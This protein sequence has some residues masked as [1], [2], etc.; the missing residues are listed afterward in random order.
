MPELWEDAIALNTHSDLEFELLPRA[1][2]LPER[3]VWTFDPAAMAL[4]A[5]LEHYL[6]ADVWPLPVPADRDNYY[7]PRHF[8]YWLSGLGVALETVAY[9]KTYGVRRGAYLELGSGSGRVMRHMAANA[10]FETCW[11]FDINYR[12]TVWINRNLSGHIR[13]VQN[14]AI[15]H[16]PIEDRSI[17]CVSAMSVFTHIDSFE[18]Q[19]LAELRRIMKPGAIALITIVTDHQLRIM[20]PEWP[21]YDAVTQ[22]AAWDG[23][24]LERLGSTD[25]VVFRWDK[26]SPYTSN[27]FY[28]KGYI[29]ATW[30]KFF[31]ILKYRHNFEMY[32]DLL[33]LRRKD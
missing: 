21:M 7:G 19:W 10:F 29:Q 2:L 30:S 16:L 18:L 13:A 12:H 33:V 3:E 8:E 23:T 14:S 26:A 17:D 11:A 4:Q 28:S 20:S 9:C 15:P 27:V 6:R 31:D 24:A 1:A 5:P 22:H 32:Q 25:K